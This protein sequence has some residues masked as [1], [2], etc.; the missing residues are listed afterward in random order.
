MRPAIH[1]KGIM[2]VSF[3][4]KA[5]W[6]TKCVEYTSAPIIIITCA[7]FFFAGPSSVSAQMS[8]FLVLMCHF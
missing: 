2:K 3:Y 5:Q 4:T 8:Q 6:Q 1:I 7:V